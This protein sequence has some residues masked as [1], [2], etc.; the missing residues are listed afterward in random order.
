M[1]PIQKLLQVVT[2]HDH[3]I[4]YA[5]CY[6]GFIIEEVDC[7]KKMT[8]KQVLFLGLIVVNVQKEE[9]DLR[10]FLRFYRSP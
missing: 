1:L 5:V 8:M 9:P 3:F 2:S 7:K 10:S 6:I 4:K